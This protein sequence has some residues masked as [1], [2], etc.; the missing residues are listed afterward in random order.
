M[1]V[2]IHHLLYLGCK[3]AVAIN[4]NGLHFLHLLLALSTSSWKWLHVFFVDAVMK[5]LSQF[6]DSKKLH[7]WHLTMA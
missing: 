5:V 3:P 2:L 7:F 6:C 4:I 1:G